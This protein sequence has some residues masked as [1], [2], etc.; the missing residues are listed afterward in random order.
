MKCLLDLQTTFRMPLNLNSI[1]SPPS[2]SVKEGQGVSLALEAS[3]LSNLRDALASDIFLASYIFLASVGLGMLENSWILATRAFLPSP[4]PVLSVYIPAFSGC[5][6][7]SMSF[8]HFLFLSFECP[9]EL[10]LTSRVW[11]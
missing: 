9:K 10:W 3:A 5:Y 2:R 8:I 1:L 6:I 4:T 11:Q 7:F